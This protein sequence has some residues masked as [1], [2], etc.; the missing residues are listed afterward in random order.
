MRKRASAL[1]SRTVDPCTHSNQV[2]VITHPNRR[3]YVNQTTT[4]SVLRARNAA[5]RISMVKAMGN[6]SR[7]MGRKLIRRYPKASRTTGG[8]VE[9]TS[10]FVYSSD[11]AVVSSV[12]PLSVK[13]ENPV[14]GCRMT[15]SRC[16]TPSV[17]SASLR[18][19]SRIWPPT[20]SPRL[21]KAPAHLPENLQSPST[22]LSFG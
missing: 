3:Q 11:W 20:S 22:V 18:G 1:Q 5:Q 21:R 19:A 2:P 13:R 17:F 4:E 9:S 16:C 8:G 6:N 7:L 14:R 15:T 10:F 12:Q